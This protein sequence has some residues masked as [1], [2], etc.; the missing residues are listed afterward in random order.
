MTKELSITPE[1]DYV[2]VEHH[3]LT[4][5]TLSSGL[6]IA[7]VNKF[8]DTLIGTVVAV[9]KTSPYPLKVEVGDHVYFTEKEVKSKTKIDNK[10]YLI[11]SEKDILGY[12]PHNH[13][14]ND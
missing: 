6:V 8:S 11:L 14:H 12:K 5:T 4:Q 9:S 10:E 1:H 3:K 7:E 2:F 13:H